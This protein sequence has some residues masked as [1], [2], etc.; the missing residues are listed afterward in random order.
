[1]VRVRDQAGV[2]EWA[3]ELTVEWEAVRDV[4]LGADLVEG[5]VE[6]LVVDSAAGLAGAEAADSVGVKAK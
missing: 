6:D 1:L 5:S 2:A 3:A 4:V